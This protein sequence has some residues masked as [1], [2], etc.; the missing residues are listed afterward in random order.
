MIAERLQPLVPFDCFAVYRKREESVAALYLGG[1]LAKAFTERP[2]PLGEGLSGWVADSERPIINGNPTVE[3]NF[4]TGNESI[5]EDSS[6]L[7]IPLF[8]LNGVAF[9]V[10][11]LYSR[12]HAAFSKDHLRILQAIESNFALALRNTLRFEAADRAADISHLREFLEAISAE[13]ADA[14][15]TGK[16]FGAAVFD[17]HVLAAAGESNAA[18]ILRAISE[19]LQ[20]RSNGALTDI[21]TCMEEGAMLFS[22]AADVSTE[23]MTAVLEDAARR[24]CSIIYPTQTAPMGAGVALYPQDGESAEQLLGSANRRMHRRTQELHRERRGAEASV[25]L[26]GAL[27][28]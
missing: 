11:T 16:H 22:T 9:G 28:L 5:T 18:A 12:E 14:G 3:A 25:T 23:S 2:I 27:T 4:E 17:A 15:R 10:L 20:D 13:V 24:V 8:D 6:A 21:R 19:E 26:A 1:L 7:S